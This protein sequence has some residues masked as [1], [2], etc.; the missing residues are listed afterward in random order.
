MV[1]VA[2]EVEKGLGGSSRSEEATERVEDVAELLPGSVNERRR[3]TRPCG[4]DL[5]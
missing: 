5:S 1:E 4:R 2:K 3:M